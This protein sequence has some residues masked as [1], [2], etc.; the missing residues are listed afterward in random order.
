ML[1]KKPDKN[2][3]PDEVV[4]QGAA[5]QGG[6]LMG[7]VCDI[8]LLDV[9]PLTLSFETLG[10]VTTT[11]ISRYPTIS[12]SIRQVFSTAADNQAAVDVHVVQGERPMVADN[13]TLGKFVLDGIQPA[14][15][16]LPQTAMATNSLA[17]RKKWMMF[18]VKEGWVQVAMEWE[19]LD[20]VGGSRR[21]EELP[22]WKAR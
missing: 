2:I 11:L 1:G 16:G 14:P 9:T 12:T 18:K 19:R 21:L 7:G 8:L 17:Q 5:T 20:W 13:K 4:A 10:G 15:R 22:M 6:V 3:N